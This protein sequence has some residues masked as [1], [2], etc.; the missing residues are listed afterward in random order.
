MRISALFGLAVALFAGACS[1]EA[2]DLSSKSAYVSPVMGT[3]VTNWTGFYIGTEAGYGN[4]A[5]NFHENMTSGQG[6]YSSTSSLH[7]NSIDAS[8][9][10][11]GLNTGFNI[12]S[13]NYVY[14][15]MF[16]YDWSDQMAKAYI[17]SS[18]NLGNSSL[19]SAKL[20]KDDAWTVGGRA[21]YLVSSNVLMYGLAGYTQEDFT[22]SY[23]GSPVGKS[24]TFTGLT[25]GTGIEWKINSISLALEYD[26]FFGSKEKWLDV[27]ATGAPGVSNRT[28]LTSQTDDDTVKAVLKYNFDWTGGTSLSHLFAPMK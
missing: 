24:I 22:G 25:A 6:P 5:N 21:G 7:L 8:G 13:G 10:L 12:Q 9:A 16:N 18:D 17:A 2:A 1:A 19:V 11:F 14:G 4:S 20:R 28:V 23:S 26:H 3:T 15:L 27:T